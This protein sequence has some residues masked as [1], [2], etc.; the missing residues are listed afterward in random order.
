MQHIVWI[1]GAY[2]GIGAALVAE[3]ARQGWHVIATARRI[4]ALQS[5]A[6]KTGRAENIHLL[7]ADLGDLENI[8]TLSLQAWN[9]QGHLD[10]VI[11]NAGVGQWGTVTETQTEVEDQLF[12]LNYHSPVRTIKAIL[13]K[14]EKQGFGR[15]VAIGSIAGQFGQ[16]K[17]AAY[18]ASKAALTIYLES[19]K[20]ECHDSPVRIQLV[21]PG[22]ARTQIM[23][24]SMLPDGSR[25]NKTGKA[26]ENGLDPAILAKRIFQF[27]QT[28]RF[29]AVMTGSEGLALPLHYFLPG[30]FYRMLRL[31]YARK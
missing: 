9:I 6:E 31:R 10:M 5:V 13:P 11:L 27:T 21:S 14:M 17:L 30:L 19:L 8:S 12:D 23:E 29:H 4:D 1:T 22:S 16:R 28:R 15:I 24:S 18:S 7:P 20:E 2:S 25:L 3:Y 26:Q